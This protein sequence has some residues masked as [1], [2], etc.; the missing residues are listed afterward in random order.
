MTDSGN[1]APLR[2]YFPALILVLVAMI[3]A[4]RTWLQE[5]PVPK[6]TGSSPNSTPRERIIRFKVSDRSAAAETVAYPLVRKPILVTSADELPITATEARDEIKIAANYHSDKTRGSSVSTFIR[7]LCRSNLPDEAWKCVENVPGEARLLELEAFF[8]TVPNAD[9]IAIDKIRSL[10]AA[11]DRAA[12][13]TAYL[14]RI[15]L[16]HLKAVILASAGLEADYREGLDKF[17]ISK[18]ASDRAAA[19]AVIRE[20]HDLELG[21]GFAWAQAIIDDPEIDPFEKWRTIREHL[22]TSDPKSALRAWNSLLPKMTSVDPARAA[23]IVMSAYQHD[24]PNFMFRQVLSQWLKEN[25]TAARQ[26]IIVRTSD[27]TSRQLDD[28]DW[29]RALHAKETGDPE[30][31][32]NRL[33]DIRDPATRT[34]LSRVLDMSLAG[35]ERE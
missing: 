11:E 24:A 21:G 9:D 25:P 7:R 22:A 4:T 14:R 6:T 28:I 17:L 35:Q 31:A 19:T 8:L 3:L 20:I 13:F 2:R 27:A 16:P 32:A 1:P 29:V 23:H 15:P 12:A 26:W 34:T 33:A 30:E 5:P 10:P 18:L